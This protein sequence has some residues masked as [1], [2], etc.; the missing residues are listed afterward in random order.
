MRLMAEFLRDFNRYGVC[1]KAPLKDGLVDT[2]DT[3]FFKKIVTLE[4]GS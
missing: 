1:I 2:T 3:N 4:D